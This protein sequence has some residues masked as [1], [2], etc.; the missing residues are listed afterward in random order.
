MS[1]VIDE[2][3]GVAFPLI[4]GHRSTTHTGRAVIADSLR[5]VAP[6]LAL[7]AES[8]ANWRRDYVKHFALSTEIGAAS[9]P[10]A[11]QIARDGLAS[12]RSRM[13][14]ATPNGDRNLTLDSLTGSA[15]VRTTTVVGAS[16]ASESLQV[17]YRG[18]ILQGSALVEQLH[19]WADDGIVEPAFVAA[20]IALIDQPDALRLPGRTVV[21]LGAAASMG[22]L[23]HLTRWGA[24]VMAIDVPVPSV[25]A[26][27]H[28]AA[29]LG[30]SRVLLPQVEGRSETGLSLT[31]ELG[32][33]SNWLNEVLADASGP[34]LAAH[35]YAD[36]GTHVEL[37]AAGDLL[38]TD[39]C[40]R[41]PDAGLAYLATPTDSFLAPM[42]AVNQARTR[43]HESAWNGH[44]KRLLRTAS[45]R[46]LFRPAYEELHTDESGIQWG[47]V[48]TLV[49]VQ[50]PNYALAKR[51]QRWRAMIADHEGT[52]VS[53][54]VA[55]SAWTHSVTK[56]KTLAAVFRAA[57]RF[58]VEIFQ[59]DTASALMA[60][61]LAADLSGL[62]PERPRH[63][64]ALLS[65][66]AAH[67]GLWRQPFTPRS[68]LGVA[69]ASGMLVR[70]GRPAYG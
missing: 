35:F 16:T 25:Q 38:A 44:T 59:S 70:G 40:E 68:A 24:A 23:I 33:T 37:T 42:D 39:L 2:R 50:G 1:G 55:P 18:Q 58:G 63:P 64:E 12:L 51:A 15:K 13:R 31:D 36:G 52:P 22:P 56:N 28:E 21:L 14:L 34:V 54:N 26:R 41:R 49:E 69:A 43:F 53:A 10:I 48:D 17:P 60:A 3:T 66:D 29:H 27:L 62:G 45:R 30:A 19:S 65:H 6:D 47:C 67:G 46:T 4:E 7:S 61:K 9:G 20:L 32:A 11:L 57:H 5:H 8:A